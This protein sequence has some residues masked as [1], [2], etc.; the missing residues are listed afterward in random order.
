[1]NHSIE[2]RGVGMV[3]IVG[4]V[5]LLVIAAA[6]AYYFVGRSA[7][8]AE[9]VLDEEAGI[10]P[11]A[12]PVRGASPAPTN[13]GAAY[14]GAVLAGTTSPLLDFHKADFDAAVRSNK[15]VVLYFYANWCPICRAEFPKMQAAFNELT[16]DNVVGFRVNFSDNETDDDEVGLARQHG[17]AYQHTKVFIKNG[18]Q[19]LKSPETWEQSRY[20]TEI[21]KAT[22]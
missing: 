4:V 10:I 6:G 9:Q 15:L 22:K 21:T 12:T 16:D 17:I 5:A 20:V 14:Q 8:P 18:Q 19:V 2:Q 3:A 1:M 7:A 13:S 11:T